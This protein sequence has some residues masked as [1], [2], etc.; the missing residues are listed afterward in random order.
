MNNLKI[1]IDQVINNPKLEINNYLKGA[2]N[3]KNYKK[4]KLSRSRG[5][6]F[7]IR[8]TITIANGMEKNKKIED[9]FKV[10]K[11]EKI[12]AIEKKNSDENLGGTKETEI[13]QDNTINNNNENEINSGL[14]KFNQNHTQGKLSHF[15]SHAS[16][17]IIVK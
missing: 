5:A 2:M 7:D 6:S 14:N 3:K 10:S 9:F 13:I 1:Y 17:L 11:K 12:E 8:E 15:P 4:E 16:N